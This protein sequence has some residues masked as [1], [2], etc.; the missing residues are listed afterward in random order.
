MTDQ[1]V[2]DVNNCD[3]NALNSADVDNTIAHQKINNDSTT[4][5][6]PLNCSNYFSIY[7]AFKDLCKNNADYFRK[8]E[9]ENG[10]RFY[11]A[12]IG[13]MDHIE[14]ARRYV[15]DIKLFA[16]EYDFNIETIGNG[17][18]SF[19]LVVRSC[20]NHGLK[21]SSYVMQHRGSLLFRKSLYMK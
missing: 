3:A 18:R 7:D 10:Q 13:L 9:S 2:D 14:T 17:Y 8:D 16:H 4:T 19:L 21:L 1:N 12:Y 5:V 15:I 6:D 20:I 11:C